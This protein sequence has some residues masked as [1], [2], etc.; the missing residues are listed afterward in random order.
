MTPTLRRLTLTLFAGLLALGPAGA[1]DDE[2]GV[3]TS[4]FGRT[5]KGYKRQK[6]PDGSWVREY[7]AMT[8][9][10]PETGTIQDNAQDKVRFVALATVLAEHLARLGYFPA[11]D[12]KKV[13]L[14]IVVNWG[15]TTP[16]NENRSGTDNVLAAMNSVT[17]L[18]PATPPAIVTVTEQ[19]AAPQAEV[20]LT[21]SVEDIQRQA[22]QSQLEGALMTQGMF[23]RSRDQTNE[24]NA[25]LLGYT[26]DLSKSG[27]IQ[28]LVGGGGTYEG[29]LADIEEPRYYV[30]LKAFDFKKTVQEKKPTMQWVTRMSMR[31]PG[32][33][34]ADRAAAMIAYSA[35]RF[36]QNTDGL[37]RKLYPEYKVNL[38]DI[39]FLGVSDRPAAEAPKA[40]E[41]KK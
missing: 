26:G 34:F 15:R 39:K 13:D 4:V 18:G 41:T 17:N 27:G 22:A 36:G 7:Y 5:D 33:S 23:N 8:N 10:G 38:E 37:E 24:R 11:T 40:E 2:H 12:P 9:G 35:S 1:A 14:L 28:R 30:I 19:S 21:G 16:G 3:L 32:N 20:N 25:T 31:A 29:L 6:A